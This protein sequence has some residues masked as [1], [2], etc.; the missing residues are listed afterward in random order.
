MKTKKYL[1][2]LLSL[3][4][5]GLLGACVPAAQPAAGAAVAPDGQVANPELVVAEQASE[6]R[7][8][9]A[10]AISLGLGIGIGA[11]AGIIFMLAVGLL[12]QKP[13]RGKS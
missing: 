10:S 2:Y 4:L 13:W 5:V 6:R 3:G 1:P 12:I 11:M 7:T 8:I 9:Q